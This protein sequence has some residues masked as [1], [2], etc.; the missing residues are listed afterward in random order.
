MSRPYKEK[1]K[2][3]GFDYIFLFFDRIDQSS[4]Q[5]RPGTQDFLDFLFFI[6]G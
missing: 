3:S 4:Q 6:S 1:E 2:M 5:L